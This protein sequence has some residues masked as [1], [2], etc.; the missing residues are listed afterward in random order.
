LSA[1]SRERF[2]V[3][4]ESEFFQ[5]SALDWPGTPARAPR[6]ARWARRV[7][8][9]AL[10]A[11]A[12]ALSGAIAVSMSPAARHARGRP[13]ARGATRSLASSRPAAARSRPATVQLRARLARASHLE[14][15]RVGRSDRPGGRLRRVASAREQIADTA[16]RTLAPATGGA[17]PV[18]GAVHAAHPAFAGIYIAPRPRARPAEFGFER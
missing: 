18:P 16:R 10:V 13:A 9:A 3:V 17:Q 14:P 5:D 4:A 11:T 2:R 7:S 8:G 1:A 15:A 6:E 12:G